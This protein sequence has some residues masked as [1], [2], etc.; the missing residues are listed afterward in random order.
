M[1]TRPHPAHTTNT[2]V[3]APHQQHFYPVHQHPP[4]IAGTCKNRTHGLA[5]T[6]LLSGGITPSILKH[7][8]ELEDNYLL[9]P[10]RPVPGSPLWNIQCSPVW[11]TYSTGFKTWRP[12]SYIKYEGGFTFSVLTFQCTGRI[13]ECHIIIRVNCFTEHTDIKI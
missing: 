4:C 11:P 13:F 3:T 2:P 7:H 5:H 1:L 9:A 8:Q 6:N 10:P 12:N